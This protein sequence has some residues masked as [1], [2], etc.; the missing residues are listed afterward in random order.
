MFARL[1][2]SVA[3]RM[4][5]TLD[6]QSMPID[7]DQIEYE[8]H[9][10]EAQQS[11]TPQSTPTIVTDYTA[12]QAATPAGGKLRSPRT[13]SARAASGA[14]VLKSTDATE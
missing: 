7:R 1:S 6:I 4:Q 3:Q 9:L 8:S 12:F 11:S 13:N 14:I 5:K 10:G 2:K